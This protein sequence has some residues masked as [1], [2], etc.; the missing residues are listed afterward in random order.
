MNLVAAPASVAAPF[1]QMQAVLWRNYGNS[2]NAHIDYPWYKFQKISGSSSYSTRKVTLCL[3]EDITR[4]H[5]S[6]HTCKKQSN[7]C[8]EP[9]D[10]QT[11][12][13]PIPYSPQKRV[14]ASSATTKLQPWHSQTDCKFLTDMDDRSLENSRYLERERGGCE[15]WFQCC[16]KR[17]HHC[18]LQQQLYLNVW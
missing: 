1:Q 13:F 12:T 16:R 9:P 17:T 5:D 15:V 10:D 8:R 2:W 4:K 6:N 14:L 11:L 18:R 3:L 7:H